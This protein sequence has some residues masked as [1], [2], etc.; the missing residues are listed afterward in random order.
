MML[1]SSD[2]T[3][4]LCGLMTRFTTVFTVRR[5]CSVRGRRKKGTGRAEG[6]K[7]KRGEKRRERLP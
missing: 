2:R 5:V 6:E 3:L 4:T 1:F 7:R